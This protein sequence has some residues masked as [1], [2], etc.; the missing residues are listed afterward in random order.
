[1]VNYIYQ[2]VKIANDLVIKSMESVLVPLE[3]YWS[4]SVNFM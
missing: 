2:N 1:M 3:M 4:H